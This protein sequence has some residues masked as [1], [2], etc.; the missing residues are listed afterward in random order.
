MD[1][2]PAPQDGSERSLEFQTQVA[3]LL[4]DFSRGGEEICF[5]NR[6]KLSEFMENGWSLELDFEE[7]GKNMIL[8]QVTVNEDTTEIEQS[9]LPKRMR[10][11]NLSLS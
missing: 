3:E 2:R 8:S 10:S 9:N 7:L 6:E 4:A 5:T 11:N 1:W